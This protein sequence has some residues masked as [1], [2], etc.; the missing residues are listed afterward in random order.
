MKLKVVR[1]K[2][3]RYRIESKKGRFDPV[4]RTPT[5]AKTF[6]RKNRKFVEKNTY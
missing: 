6:L 4:F 3:G 2:S 5:E 1:K